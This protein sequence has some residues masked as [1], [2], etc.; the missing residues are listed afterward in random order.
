MS[1]RSDLAEK[2]MPFGKHNGLTLGWITKID[3]GYARWSSQNMKN[4]ISLA[5]KQL[6]ISR[7]FRAVGSEYS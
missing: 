7:D 5:F 2:V 6:L 3:L 1:K 4:S